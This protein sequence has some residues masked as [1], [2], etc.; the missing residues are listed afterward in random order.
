MPKQIFKPGVSGNP[1]GRPKDRV[2][3]KIQIR[4][5]LIDALEKDA[6]KV[7]QMIVDKALKG[8]MVAAKIIMDRLIPQQKAVVSGE[9]GMR[10][11]VVN[12]VVGSLSD[13]NNKNN[14]IDVTPINITREDK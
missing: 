10:Q 13:L 9:E 7:V 11:P 4:D 3:K 14:T 6:V 12:I 8:D 5:Q 1:A 2:S